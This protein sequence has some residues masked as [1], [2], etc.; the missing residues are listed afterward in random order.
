MGEVQ[1]PADVEAEGERLRGTEQ[2]A[3]VE[4][5]AEASAGER[6]GDDVSRLPP[7]CR[8][9]PGGEHLG[10]VRVFEG[11]G[12]F[13]SG[14]EASCEVGIGAQRRIEHPDGHRPARGP[15][16]TVDQGGRRTHRHHRGEVEAIGD[17][18]S[19]QRGEVHG[20]RTLPADS[21]PL[22]SGGR[23]GWVPPR[24]SGMMAR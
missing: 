12:R 6:L 7:R 8:H 5:V 18:R 22:G 19:A 24:T 13:E 23:S 3:T 14:R 1:R 16:H 4:Q 11:P 17:L 20:H 9:D 2:S 21:S 10:D 15:L